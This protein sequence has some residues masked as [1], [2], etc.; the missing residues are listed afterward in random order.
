MSMPSLGQYI[1]VGHSRTRYIFEV[2]PL[3]ANF[4]DDFAAVYIFSRP[5]DTHT[6]VPICVGETEQLG[7]HIRNHEKWACIRRNDAACICIHADSSKRSRKAKAQDLIT[8]YDP[9][10]NRE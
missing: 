10:C 9:A 2:Y 8:R 1:F 7:I 5:I 4:K 3:D 6:Q